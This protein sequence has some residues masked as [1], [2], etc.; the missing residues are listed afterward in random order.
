MKAGQK[1]FAAS[2][3]SAVLVGSAG[4]A[5]SAQVKPEPTNRQYTIESLPD[6]NYKFCSQ[7]SSTK[8]M[9]TNPCFWF[10]KQGDRVVGQYFYPYTEASICIKGQVNK[11]TV[12]GQALENL[13]GLSEPPQPKSLKQKGN[14][15]DSYL[16]VGLDKISK[17]SRSDVAGDYSAQAH[18]SSAILHLADFYPNNASNALPPQNCEI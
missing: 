16:K 1:I 5:L 8:E 2:L 12:T 10:G 11:D 6:G 18:Y 7:T 9:L 17:V 15:K 14:E 3:I 13:W 4:S